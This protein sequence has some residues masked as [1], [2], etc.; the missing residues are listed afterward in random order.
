MPQKPDREHYS[1]CPVTYESASIDVDVILLRA[2]GMS[3]WGR[4]IDSFICDLLDAGQCPLENP[5]TECPFAQR[6]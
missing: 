5:R 4:R 3:G 1:Q 6:R 2:L